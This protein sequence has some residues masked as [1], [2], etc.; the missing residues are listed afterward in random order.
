[1]LVHRT[2]DDQSGGD[3][4]ATGSTAPDGKAST[5]RPVGPALDGDHTPSDDE[6][7]TS[8]NPSDD[9]KTHMIGDALKSVYQRT[10]EEEIPGDFLDLLKQL[11]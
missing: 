8:A 9:G 2:N 5:L 7:E 3:K 11:K 10:L 4:P 1:M 6:G